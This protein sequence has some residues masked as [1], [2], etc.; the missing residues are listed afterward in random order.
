MRSRRGTALILVLM[1]TL[2]IAGLSIAAIFMSSS[3][4]LLS[5]FYDTEREYRLAAEAGL[6]IARSRLMRD[7]ALAIPDT[8][9]RQLLAGETMRDADGV[10]IR[11]VRVN[12]YAATTGDTSGAFLPTVTLIAAAYDSRGTRYVRRLDLRRESFSRYAILTDLFPSG[13]TQGPGTVN[14]RIHTNQTWR[15]SA[16]GNLYRDTVSAVSALTGTATYYSDTVTGVVRVRYP[17]DSTF[18]RLDS[19][20]ALGNLSFA[21]V[22]GG[23]RGSR[24]EFVAFDA[25]GDSTVGATEGFARVFD[26]ASSPGVDTSRLR[27]S[28]TTKFIL[29]IIPYYDWD[30]RVVQNQ[31]GAFYR[32]GGRWHF[33]PL[34]THRA[35]WARAVIQSTAGSAYPQVDA[36]R[37]DVMDDYTF[38]ADTAVLIG[39]PTARCFPAGSP[40]LMT[41]ERMTNSSGVITGTSADTVPFGVVTPPVGWPADAPSGYGGNDTTFTVRSRTCRFSTSSTTGRCQNLVPPDSIRDL[42]SWRAFGGTPVTGV[43]TAVRQAAVESPYLWPITAPY[44]PTARGVISATAGPLYVSGTVRGRVTLRVA[45]RATIV[46]R[47]KYASDPNDPLVA[48]CTDQFGLL[49]IGDVLVVEG[50]TSRVRMIWNGGFSLR[51]IGN[52]GGE[53]GFTVHGNLMSLTGTVGIENPASSMGGLASQLPCP[54]GAASSTASN[55]G[56]LAITGGV[57]MET[58]SSIYTSALYSGSRYY[59]TADRCQSTTRRPPFFPLTNRYTFIRTLEVGASRANTP[60]KIRAILMRLKGKS[61]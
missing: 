28:E 40:F 13:Q 22:S 3:A 42:G 1:M 56:C 49:A 12:V 10:A 58:F 6:A 33:F 53:N 19:I 55:G 4:G 32:R 35:S 5:A 48:S 46:D 60:A 44:N 14:G 29:G 27:A 47:I 26:L 16:S 39:M 17:R 41:A 7:T 23:G 38:A 45:G 36:A 43:S 52:M 2:A 51:T 24:I 57:A 21:P 59:G 34:S 61:L 37:M 50:L 18:A 9:M 54:Y 31:C 25:N 20:A 30:S 11:S 15:S 8:G